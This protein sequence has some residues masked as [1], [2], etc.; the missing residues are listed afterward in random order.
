M[1]IKLSLC[2]IVTVLNQDTNKRFQER[3]DVTDNN[4]GILL[5]I[6]EFL[7]R[8]CTLASESMGKHIIFLPLGIVKICTH[9]YSLSVPFK[10]HCTQPHYKMLSLAEYHLCYR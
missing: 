9:M 2:T 8:V 1:S 6:A 10:W 4:Q 3:A 5:S 7:P